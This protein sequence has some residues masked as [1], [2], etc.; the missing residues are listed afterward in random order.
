MT[1]NP[2]GLSSSVSTFLVSRGEQEEFTYKRWVAHALYVTESEPPP[3]DGQSLLL[4]W[5]RA[6][7]AVCRHLPAS[8]RPS[9]A[10]RGGGSMFITSIRSTSHPV[11]YWRPPPQVSSPGSLFSLLPSWVLP[12][13][14]VTCLVFFFFF[15]LL[16]A[17]D[18]ISLSV[19]N[20]LFPIVSETTSCC[21]LIAS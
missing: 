7:S 4:T 12:L 20:V 1:R 21:K 18:F 13:F 19:G 17:K 16:S 10:A 3:E 14:I 8:D 11:V 15:F 5:V 2:V 6:V 9:A